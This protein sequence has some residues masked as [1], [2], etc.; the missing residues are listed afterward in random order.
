MVYQNLDKLAKEAARPITTLVSIED[1]IDQALAKL[2]EKNIDPK[3]SYFYVA[4][5]KN[6]LLGVVSTRKLLLK[7]RTTK[8]AEIM[9]TNLITL[10]EDQ[11][12]KEA[13]E[14]FYNYRLLAF[15]VVDAENRLLGIVDIDMYVE[16]PYE[17]TYNKQRSDLFQLIGFS[18]EEEKRSSVLKSYLMRMPW[19]GCV[20]AGG[21]FCFSIAYFYQAVLL[22]MLF[23]AMFLPLV[24]MLSKSVAIQS[25]TSTIQYLKRP[26]AGFWRAL[27]G[28]FK[29]LR[30]AFLIALTSALIVFGA[31]YWFEA[32]W[33]ASSV[34]GLGVL[35]TVFFSALFGLLLPYCVS[36]SRLDL[37]LASGPVVLML[38][39]VLTVLL[40]L[41]VA[42]LM[43]A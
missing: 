5:S 27:G 14:L 2:I 30:V 21:L 25:M 35:V 23:V 16:E 33:L 7:E 20:L 37:R 39:D 18:L 24:L 26:K 8:I 43:L 15:P 6:R 10:G 36:K 1:T 29:E 19:L 32:L 3:I 11:T 12:L 41:S 34:I 40:Y 42:S 38:S 4:D 22:K 13:L 17:I 28:G 9:D 31:A